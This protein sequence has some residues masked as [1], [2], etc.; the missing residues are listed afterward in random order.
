MEFV[1]ILVVG[2]LIAIWVVANLRPKHP[3]QRAAPDFS[4]ADAPP[5]VPPVWRKGAVQSEPMD[6][7]EYLRAIERH[8]KD[9][10]HY[11]FP[12]PPPRPQN[13]ESARDE[14]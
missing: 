5:P 6:D 12:S 10:S 7:L 1:A 3:I 14:Y 8:D 11:P 9:P 2:A 13:E 4:T